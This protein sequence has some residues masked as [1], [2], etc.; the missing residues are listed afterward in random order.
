[1]ILIVT[2]LQLTIFGCGC[3]L[4]VIVEDVHIF[5]LEFLM[6][7]KHFVSED[8]KCLSFLIYCDCSRICFLCPVF[9]IIILYN[10]YTD[11][12]LKLSIQKCLKCNINEIIVAV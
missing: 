8:L 12:S 10:V 7:N 11:K 5:L 6:Q 1:M 2:L 4:N 3:D 9:Y